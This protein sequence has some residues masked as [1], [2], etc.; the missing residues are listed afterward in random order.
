MASVSQL[1]DSSGSSLSGATIVMSETEGANRKYFRRRLRR[2]FLQMKVNR[3]AVKRSIELY[4]YE[5]P[6]DCQSPDV[7]R[8]ITALLSLDSIEG[9]HSLSKQEQLQMVSEKVDYLLRKV[10]NFFGYEAGWNVTENDKYR[11]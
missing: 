6:Y 10:L 8:E 7:M 9:L 4:D 2:Q 5:K 1:S 3:A 11:L